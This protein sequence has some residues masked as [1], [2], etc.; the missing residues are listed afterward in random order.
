MAE[1]FFGDQR[2]ATVYLP[3]PAVNAAP[4]TQRL[5]FVGDKLDL[6]DRQGMFTSAESALL[7]T[8]AEMKL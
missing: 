5:V 1:R 7:H 3:I 2:V 4:S 8:P 6:T